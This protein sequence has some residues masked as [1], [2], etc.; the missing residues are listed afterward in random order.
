MAK[1]TFGGTD[2]LMAELFAEQERLERKAAEMLGDAGKIVIQAWKDAITEAGHA[3][4]GKSKRGTGAMIEGIKA[5]AIKKNGDAYTCSVYPH[6][7]DKKGVSNAEKAFVLN[8][9]TSKIRGDHFVQAAEDKSATI[10]EE[11]MQRAWERD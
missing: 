3:P 5:T 4:P 9:G 2:E 8:Y 11:A 1:M 6:G 7:K 10:A